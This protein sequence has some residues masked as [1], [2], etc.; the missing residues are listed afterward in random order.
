MLVKRHKL[1]RAAWTF[2]KTS[3]FAFYD[4]TGL[5]LHDGE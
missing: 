5:K 3:P 1:K 4:Q 2:C